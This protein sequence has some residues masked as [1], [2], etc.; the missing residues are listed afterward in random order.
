MVTRQD[1]LGSPSQVDRSFPLLID[2]APQLLGEADYALAMTLLERMQR[3][4]ELSFAVRS[5]TSGSTGSVGS[6]N[7]SSVQGAAG[8][9]D[10]EQRCQLEPLNLT[11]AGAM[12]FWLSSPDNDGQNR[13]EQLANAGAAFDS[14]AVSQ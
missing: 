5:Q 1:G 10:P 3:E 8:A 4:V 14:Y 2:A 9:E 7:S 13:Q 11:P 6:S 12:L